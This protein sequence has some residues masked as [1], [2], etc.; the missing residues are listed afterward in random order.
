MYQ[1]FCS[2]PV[3]NLTMKNALLS[4]IIP[5][6]NEEAVIAGTLRSVLAEEVEVIVV[7][8]GSRDRT[9]AIALE[10][11]VQ[12]V[13]T[14]A[15]RGVQMNQGAAVARGDLLLF[16][17]ADTLLPEHYL[18]YIFSCVRKPTFA[19]G[20]FH[21]NLCGMRRRLSFISRMANVRSKWLGLVYGDQGLFMTKDL[22]ESVGGYPETAIMEDFMLVQKMRAKG[23]IEL[24]NAE[25]QS[26]GRRWDKYGVWYPTLINQMVIVGFFLGL[27]P[28]VLAKIYG[29][30]K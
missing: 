24:A 17:H 27:S 25:V 29:V 12:V 1:S 9:C 18:Q 2:L 22:F 26:S 7:D 30:R 6:L 4:V 15:G 10:L 16:L 5:C 21:L 23:T 8:G 3:A 28:D 14:S 19:V 11:G 13:H 20:A